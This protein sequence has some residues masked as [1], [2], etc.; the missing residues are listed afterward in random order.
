MVGFSYGETHSI[1]MGGKLA[2]QKQNIW[3]QVWWIKEW[4]RFI[5]YDAQIQHGYGKDMP[6]I[7]KWNGFYA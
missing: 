7:W 2:E 6:R 1:Q 3:V 5:G 4:W